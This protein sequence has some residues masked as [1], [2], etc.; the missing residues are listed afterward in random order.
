M[1]NVTL[2]ITMIIEPILQGYDVEGMLNGM[3]DLV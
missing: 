3:R 1:S 2:H